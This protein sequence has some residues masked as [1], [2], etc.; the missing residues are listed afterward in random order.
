MLSALVPDSPLFHLNERTRTPTEEINVEKNHIFLLCVRRRVL[1]VLFLLFFLYFFF[2]VAVHCSSTKFIEI[3]FFFPNDFDAQPLSCAI[4]NGVVL[5]LCF[6]WFLF[7]YFLIFSDLLAREKFAQ[8]F[9]I[10]HNF[11]WQNYYK[12]FFFL[13]P[14]LTTQNESP[15]DRSTLN[16][17]NLLLFC[18]FSPFFRIY[19]NKSN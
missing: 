12:F 15:Y 1:R 17:L 19:L 14:G 16:L 2:S 3:E 4:H 13:V 9:C 18:F 6:L 8:L 7:F 10:R 5:W 11:D